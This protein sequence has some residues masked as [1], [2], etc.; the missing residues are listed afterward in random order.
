[1]DNICMDNI[2]MD[3]CMDMCMDKFVFLLFIYNVFAITSFGY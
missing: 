2:C 1:M 3:I